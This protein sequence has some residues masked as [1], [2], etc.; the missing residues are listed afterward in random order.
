MMHWRCKSPSEDIVEVVPIVRQ[1]AQTLL[2]ARSRRRNRAVHQATLVDDTTHSGDE[3]HLVAEPLDARD[4]K[5][6]NPLRVARRRTFFLQGD[7]IGERGLTQGESETEEGIAGALSAAEDRDR[8]DEQQQ[9]ARTEQNT[10]SA[11]DEASGSEGQ[12][13][14]DHDARARESS[15]HLEVVDPGIADEPDQHEA[16]PQYQTYGAEPARDAQRRDSAADRAASWFRA[17]LNLC[18]HPDVQPFGPTFG[19]ERPRTGH[20]TPSAGP[21]ERRVNTQ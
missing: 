17:S 18:P 16:P 1:A 14:R 19:V 5:Q 7:A 10:A 13:G 20:R 8:S 4:V 12:D 6:T 9:Q 2:A 21:L 3:A 11:A 15:E